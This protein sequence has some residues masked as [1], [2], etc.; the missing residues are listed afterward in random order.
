M[1]VTPAAIAPFA[2]YD[3]LAIG[4]H[5]RNRFM[6]GLVD[7]DCP[8]RQFNDAGL[9][10][11]T[12]LVG[13]HS[14]ST[15]SRVPMRLVFVVDQIVGVVVADQNDI[16]PAAPIAPVGSAPRLI[17]FTAKADAAATTVTG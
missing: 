14:M 3:S 11:L 13:A 10:V 17:F 4:N 8:K 5:F 12:E 9:A 15:A 6:R 2:Q 16:A 7:Y 1:S